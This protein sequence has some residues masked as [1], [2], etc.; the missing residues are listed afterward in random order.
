MPLLLTHTP[1]PLAKERAAGQAKAAQPTFLE[2][3]PTWHPSLCHLHELQQA[4]PSHHCHQT[5]AKSS[6][7]HPRHPL[8]ASVI[9]HAHPCG[10]LPSE[11][12]FI[13]LAPPLGQF[14]WSHCSV[15]HSPLFF[16]G[17]VCHSTTLPPTHTQTHRHTDSHTHTHTCILL[18]TSQGG[19]CAIHSNSYC[20]FLASRY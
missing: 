5:L 18:K 7:A 2:G 17:S 14:S 12:H 3:M 13:H 1:S 4:Q 11:S 8:V 10:Q 6:A 16:P 15:P 9:C 19:F 20:F